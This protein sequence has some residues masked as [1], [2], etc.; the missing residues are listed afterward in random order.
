[1]KNCIVPFVIILTFIL[2]SISYSQGEAAIPF[3]VF[4]VSPTQTAMGVTGTSLQSDDPYGFLLNPAQL[5][6]TSQSN[7]LSFIFYPSEI[8]WLGSNIITISGIAFNLGYNFKNLVGIPLSLGFGFANPEIN[9]GEYIRTNPNDPTPLGTFESKDYYYAYSLGIGVDYFVQFNAGITYK[10]I[11]SI[12][13]DQPVGEEQGSGKAEVSAIDYGLLL[14]IPVIR[15]IDDDPTLDIFENVP[16]IPFLN[17]SFGLSRTNI[18][19]EVYYIDPAQADP[20]PRSARLG[21]GI[22]TGMD[23]QFAD[24]DI[25]IF[26]LAFTVDAWDILIE[27]D[28]MGKTEYQSGLGDINFDKHVIQIKGDDKVVS[29]AG[30]QISLLETVVF[31]NGHFNGRGFHDRK[32]N[33]IEMRAKGL[34]KLL[35]KFSDDPTMKFIADHFDIRYYNTNYFSDYILETKITGIALVINGFEFW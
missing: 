27:R 22:S 12:L 4:P 17:I 28:D 2:Q 25:N 16:S 7:N 1:M 10:S 26:D 6:Y 35:D 13:S 29:H 19:D 33:G 21:Y 32:T 34:L 20:L 14:N 9:Y 8:N 15:L 30:L 24:T 3:L 31:R 5:G 18:G 23:L 11:I